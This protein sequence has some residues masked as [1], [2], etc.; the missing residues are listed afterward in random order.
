MPGDVGPE[1]ILGKSLIGRSVLAVAISLFAVQQIKVSATPDFAQDYAAG[2]A[3]LHG[4]SIYTP[5]AELLAECWPH[6]TFTKLAGIRQP[7]PPWATLLAVPLALFSFETARL[8]WCLLCALAVWGGW[9]LAR[10]DLMSCL[11]TAPIW[12]IALVLG[13]HEPVLFL[14]IAAALLLLIRAPVIAGACLALCI[15][16]KAYP[17][18][19]LIGVLLG[20]Q[21]RC[22]TAAIVGTAALTLFAE[23]ILGFGVTAQWLGVVA[24]STAGY[25]DSPHNSSLVRLVYAVFPVRPMAIAAVLAA[26]LI[27]PQLRHRRPEDPIRPMV[28]V[29]LLASP[30]SWRHYMGLV[31]VLELGRIEQFCLALAG[32]L[33]LLVSMGWIAPVSEVLVQSPLV[34][35]LIVLWMRTLKSN[36]KSPLRG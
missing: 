1:P 16:L 28:P 12:C 11:V 20:R 19:L 25:V 31:N 33:A 17:A 36:G 2:W 23:L 32:G 9:Q 18:V 10:T 26:I 29:M 14:L 27:W 30:I 5:T 6:H 34:L 35:V 24:H 13:T 8:V 3:F 4:R 22:L 21:W 15:A 7:H